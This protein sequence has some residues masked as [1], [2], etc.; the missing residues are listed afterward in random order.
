MMYIF[1]L[2]YILLYDSFA[3]GQHYGFVYPNATNPTHQNLVLEVGEEIDVE[4]RIP[5]TSTNL[6]IVSNDPDYFQVFS[7][8]LHF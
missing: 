6:A 5:F 1:S 7:R 2:L 4:W 3:I 8:M